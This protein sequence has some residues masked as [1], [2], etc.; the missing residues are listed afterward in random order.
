MWESLVSMKAEFV[1]GILQDCD[2]LLGDALPPTEIMDITFDGI[3]FVVVGKE[4][5]CCASRHFCSITVDDEGWWLVVGTMV[6]WRFKEP[7]AYQAT[8]SD[9]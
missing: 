8:L 1:G 2:S 9:A 3:E 4:Y 6:R 5:N 7:D